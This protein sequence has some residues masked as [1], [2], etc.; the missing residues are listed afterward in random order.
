MKTYPYNS[1]GGI[2]ELIEKREYD[3]V[4]LALHDAHN[5]IDQQLQDA[6]NRM[7]A[8][9]GNDL[10]KVYLNYPS[11]NYSTCMDAVRARLI[12]AAKGE[13]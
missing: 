6:V 4:I 12:S 1:P 11:V 3:A 8:V 7:E 2:I 13:S 5:K 9:S 10:Y